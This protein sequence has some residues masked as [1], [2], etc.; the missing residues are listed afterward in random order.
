MLTYQN[1]TEGTSQ[2]YFCTLFLLYQGKG[3]QGQGP[4]APGLG[5][6]EYRSRRSLKEQS[7]R[8]CRRWAF[9]FTCLRKKPLI[10]PCPAPPIMSRYD[11]CGAARGGRP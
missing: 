6:L 7:A 11:T 9:I 10:F 8:P 2:G 1:T 4:R 5:R 3:G